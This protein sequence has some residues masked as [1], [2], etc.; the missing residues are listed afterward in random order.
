[1]SSRNETINTHRI[2]FERAAAK[3]ILGESEGLELRG[4]RR[5][6]AAASRVL[7]ESR[8]LLTALR[9]SADLAEVRAR[10]E[11]K[12]NAAA[13]FADAFGYVWPF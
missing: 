8:G 1:M 9:T 7:E 5:Q 10:I 4:S 2:A 12:R 11:R 13:R 6:V 3:Y